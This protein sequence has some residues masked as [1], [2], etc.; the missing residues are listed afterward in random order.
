M[1]RSP[2]RLGPLLAA[3]LGVAGVVL[4]A[5]ALVGPGPD[6][7]P[8]LGAT[9]SERDRSEL[10]APEVGRGE[11][12]APVLDDVDPTDPEAVARAY[13]A[14]AHS[15]LPTDAGRTHLRAAGYALPGTPP[16]TVGV[17]V[18]DAP[19]EGTEAVAVVDA[20]ELVAA[21]RAD[22]RR[23]YAA[24]VRTQVRPGAGSTSAQRYVVLARQDDGRWWVT[25]ESPWSP[26]LPAGEG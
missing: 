18:L 13:L 16:A 12:L 10:A 26:D 23:G 2:A 6:D 17:L 22:R 1:T 15:A 19:S 5:A 21:D 9:L 25:A 11:A 3:A 7:A 4:G 14:A 24:T 8:A 20:L